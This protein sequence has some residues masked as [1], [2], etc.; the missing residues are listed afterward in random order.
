MADPAY[1]RFQ[2]NGSEADLRNFIVSCCKLQSDGNLALD[3]DRII[4]VPTEVRGGKRSVRDWKRQNWG[5]REASDFKT[6]SRTPTHLILRF[7]SVGTPPERIYRE[8]ARRFPEI[9]FR[10]NFADGANNFAHTFSADR[11]EIVSAEREAT[12]KDWE[13]A[14]GETAEQMERSAEAARAAWEA[15][16]P[17]QPPSRPITHPRF[18]LRH[19]RVRRALNG[20]P[21]YG[22]PN[23]TPERESPDGRAEENFDYFMKVRL[24][25][26]SYFQSWL[27]S[28]FSV[29]ASLSPPG[30]H[31]VDRWVNQFGGGLIGDEENARIVFDS[32]QPYWEGPFAGY[33][34]MIDLGIFMGEY[35][36]LKRPRVHWTMNRGEPNKSASAQ[37]IGYKRPCLAGFPNGWTDNILQSGYGCV[38]DSNDASKLGVS[39]V[40]ST[41]VV[42]RVVKSALYVAR[43]PEGD[44]P[45]IFGDSSH[46]QL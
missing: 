38:A 21:I 7:G 1:N 44:G 13:A 8:L 41:S 9:K 5:T 11:G 42:L 15:K 32:Y 6:E 36:I 30:V 23:R 34:V 14:T 25:R 20:Y 10:A 43:L 3:F 27:R 19:W 29:D 28:N 22:I 31:N 16:N 35:I 17:P 12:D 37:P 39:A 33:N 18:W 26:L 45:I 46:E 24:E 40:S 4:A 2:A